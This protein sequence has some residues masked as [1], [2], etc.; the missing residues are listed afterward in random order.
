MKY[1]TL[2]AALLVAG[3]VRAEDKAST[4]D[5]PAALQAL[6]VDGGAV[7]SAKEA[8][9]VRGQTGTTGFALVQDKSFSITG[10]TAVGTTNLLEGVFG[11]FKF[12]NITSTGSLQVEGSFGGLQGS[13]GV[14]GGALNFTFAGKALQESFDFAGNFQQ[15][16][17]QSFKLPF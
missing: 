15:N 1:L 17:S 13:I 12:A 2:V 7:L 3:V 11:T 5:L 6:G 4:A 14:S 10:G 9:Q 16:F 8:H